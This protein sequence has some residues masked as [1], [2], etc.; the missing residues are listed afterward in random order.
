[1]QALV[2]HASGVR[3]KIVLLTSNHCVRLSAW[4]FQSG[5]LGQQLFLLSVPQ[6]VAARF[7]PLGGEGL[8]LVL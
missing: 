8:V 7:H 3:G 6:L 5:A 4:N 1:M 2:V